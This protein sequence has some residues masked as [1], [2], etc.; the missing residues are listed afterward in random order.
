MKL[1]LLVTLSLL[2]HGLSAGA[3]V[4]ENLRKENLAA[5]CIVPFDAKKRSPEQ[6]AIMLGELGINR[7]A[8]DWRPEHVGQFE[9]EILQYQKHGIE[10]FAFWGGHEE[11]FRLFEKYQIHPQIWKTIPG[12]EASG[13]QE[14]VQAAADLLEPLA[15]RTAELSCR[16]GLYNHGGWSGEPENMVAVCKLLRAR[17]HT[18]VGIVYNWHHMHERIEDWPASLELMKPYL[19]CLNLNGMNPAANPKILPLAQGEHDLPLL[20]TLIASGYDGPVGILD[21]QGNTDAKLS[22][23]DNLDGLSWLLKE[24]GSP[25]SG[26]DKPVPSALPVPAPVAHTPLNPEAVKS[27]DPSFGNALSNGMSVEAGEFRRTPPLTVECRVKLQGAD[28]YQILVASDSKASADHWE[29]FSMN[30]N[31]F[32]TAYLPGSKPDHI[33]TK[34]VITDGKWHAVA[35]LY[36]ADRVR[37]FLDGDEVA[38][39]AITRKPGGKKHPGKLGIG[40]LVEGRFRLRGAIDEVRIR[41]GIHEDV[42][43]VAEKPFAPLS[44]TGNALWNFDELKSAGPPPLRFP[45]APLNPNESPYWKNAI[46]RDR[47]YDFYAKQA[48]AYGQMNR[49]ELPDILPPFP[50]IDGGQYG[51][52]GNQNDQDTW[53]DGRIRDMDHGSMVSG[54]FRGFDLVI[55]RAVSVKLSSGLNAVFDQE[56]LTFRAA[57]QGDLVAWSDTRRGFVHGIPAGGKTQVPLDQTI[58]PSAQ[59]SYLGLYRNGRQVSFA[60]EEAGKIRYTTASAE[61]GKVVVTF[62]DKPPVSGPSQ[63]SQNVLTQIQN[64]DGT[65]YAIDTFALPHA[66]PWNALFFVGG[67]DFVS[68]ERI[69]VANIHGDVWICD[70]SGDELTWKRFAAGLHQPLGVKVVDGTMHVRCRDQIVALHDRN[71]DDEADFYECV[72][73]VQETS[74]GGHDFI[75]GLQRD[76]AGRWYF[77]S[78]NQGLCRV[79]KDGGELEVLATGLRNPNGL[80]ISPDGSAILTSVQEGNWTPASAICDVSRPG[81]FGAGGPQDGK[82]GNVPPMLYLPRGIDNSSGGQTYIDS[83]R[84]G[85]VKGQW[86]HFSGGFAKHFLILRETIGE[87]SQAAAIPLPGD[88][89]S[90]SHRGRFSP[91][92]GQLYVAGA[93]GW[94]NYG[95]DDGSLQRVR[96]TGGERYPYPVSHETRDN[97]LLLTFAEPVPET[98][99]AGEQWFAQQWN[100]RYGPAYGSPEYSANHADREGHDWLDVRSVH[101]IGDGTKLFVEIPQLR[102]VD[103]LHLHFDAAPGLEIFAT[104]HE[105]GAAF[106]NFP[107]YQNIP[108]KDAAELTRLRDTSVPPAQIGACVAC[109][110]PTR[111]VVGP[112]FAEIRKRYAGNP[113]GIV[114]WA[115][116]PQN[117]TPELPPMPSFQFMKKSDLK[118]IA[119]QIL[120]EN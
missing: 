10:F 118:K 13:Q 26:G 50:G 2:L 40:Q 102:P 48:L 59:A 35:M 12:P 88:F 120:E 85:P 55:P 115:I 67:F 78:G 25:G 43:T 11:A 32:L 37:L 110:H 68:E 82:R 20:K 71:G 107:G 108:K 81:H 30:G 70:R 7:C 75:T 114:E 56:T 79:S 73:D 76:A 5:W 119:L 38:D 101:R 84:W 9:D 65:P 57:W 53:R 58:T 90:G 83:D 69:A 103:T 98:F 61:A 52:W 24:I 95:I 109:H 16:L 14:K 44:D 74:P 36:E 80:D 92:D 94:G 99:S 42:R 31:G 34:K 72:S 54:V 22:L 19:Y 105:A 111:Q 112:S 93:Q 86:L 27:L 29:I 66:N 41:R 60:F 3:E 89:L 77:A 64:G 39:T 1:Y 116:N 47:V 63:W 18:H 91:F 17:G 113:D 62:S 49:S 106:T 4:P 96:Y 117:K 8:Y 46:N 21:H 51:H 97:G 87:G 100:Y 23:Q 28:G 6:R 104:I 33:T 45:P 15:K